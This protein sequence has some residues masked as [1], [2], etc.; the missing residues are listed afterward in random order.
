MSLVIDMPRESWRVIP[1]PEPASALLILAFVIVVSG[2]ALDITLGF[3]VGTMAIGTTLTGLGI[4][5]KLLFDEL[6]RSLL[7]VP[8]S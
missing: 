5:L 3:T 1:E 6:E 8:K 4:V 7:W 2:L